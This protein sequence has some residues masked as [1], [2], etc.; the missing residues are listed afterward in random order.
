MNKKDFLQK[1]DGY[2]NVLPKAEKERLLNYYSE[3]LEDR[4]EEGL[5]EEEAVLSLEKVEDIADQLL[6]EHKMQK[7]DTSGKISDTKRNWLLA[8][9]SPFWIFGVFAYLMLLLAGYILIGALIFTLVA[10]LI[11]FAVG[12]VAGLFSLS[13]AFPMSTIHGMLNLSVTITCAGLFIFSLWGYKRGIRRLLSWGKWMALK[14]GVLFKAF[15][16]IKKEAG[17]EDSKEERSRSEDTA[18][19]GRFRK[20]YLSAAAGLTFA[21]LAIMLVQF[22]S[23]NFDVEKLNLDPPLT[24]NTYE[25]NVEGIDE[26]SV[27]TSYFDIKVVPVTGD[28]IKVQYQENEK[29]GYQ[30]NNSGSHL[31]I[32][33]TSNRKWTEYLVAFQF[34]TLSDKKL[35]YLELPEQYAG[36]LKLKTN[37]S[38]V[39]VDDFQN[40]SKVQITSSYSKVTLNSLNMTGDLSVAN[41]NGS[42]VLSDVN[43]GKDISCNNSYSKMSLV[44]VSSGGNISLK[45]P[46]GAIEMDELTAKG[47]LSCRFSYKSLKGNLVSAHSVLI[48]APNSDVTINTLDAASDITIDLSYGALVLSEVFAQNTLKLTANDSSMRLDEA[49]G[50]TVFCKT[51]YN[52]IRFTELSGDD[53]TLQASNG[54]VSG[55]IAGNLSD[56]QLS[57]HASDG[58]SNLPEKNSGSKKLEVKTSYGDI[59]IQFRDMP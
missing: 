38:P 11:S 42:I 56:Y 23:I 20:A 12:T 55:S 59:D 44:K 21:G 51:S 32:T 58:K 4:I 30:I 43:A 1:L 10:F 48:D 54:D 19:H 39:I 53:I 5:T 46:N 47:S 31:S 37:N 36:N 3:I 16:G 29:E 8:L 41:P 9:T 52:N 15:F 28:T 33:H 40:L 7:S 13:F 35:L 49:E 17:I 27:D 2:I 45:N 22:L 18:E 50:R 24:V 26:I 57:G 34:N 6:A 14:T 25:C